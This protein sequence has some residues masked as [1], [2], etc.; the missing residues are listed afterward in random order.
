M[1]EQ[2]LAACALIVAVGAATAVV[3]KAVT[4]VFRG[5][6]KLGRLAD[7]LLGDGESLGLMERV[8]RIDARLAKVE[9][10]VQK[11]LT[12]NGGTSMKDQVARVAGHLTEDS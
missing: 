1:I 4:W 6:R 3:Y 8:A 11:E 7:D 2:I 10:V 9:V 12:H 5:I